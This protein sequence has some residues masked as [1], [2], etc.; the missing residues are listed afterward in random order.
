MVADMATWRTAI[1][2]LAAALCWST[3]SADNSYRVTIWNGLGDCSGGASCL[4]DADQADAPPPAG[5]PLASFDFTSTDPSGDLMWAAAQGMFN[6]YGDFL[7]SGSISHYTGQVSQS[8]FLNQQMSSDGNAIASF[9][10]ITGFYTSATPFTHSIMHDDGAS[11]YVDSNAVFQAPGRVTGQITSGPY[12]FDAGS[13]AFSLFY[14]AADGGP[15]VLGFGLPG[16]VA[17]A[18]PVPEPAPLLLIAGGLIAIALMR[19]RRI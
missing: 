13:H 14:V 4:F 15:A 17:S 16:A 2:G 9:F 19:R 1:L 10:M 3:A 6:T 5:T 11:L 12:N 18:V 8:D 7:D